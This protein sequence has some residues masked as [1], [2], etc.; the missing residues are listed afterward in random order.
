MKT[1]YTI[2]SFITAASGWL[3][4]KKTLLKSTLNRL[5]CHVS[6]VPAATHRQDFSPL[7]QPIFS[8]ILADLKQRVSQK[9]KH[10]KIYSSYKGLMEFFRY[11]PR[12]TTTAV[13]LIFL[14]SCFSF[15]S[16]GLLMTLYP[17]FFAIH[18]IFCEMGFNQF[19]ICLFGFEVFGNTESS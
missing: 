19:L 10:K 5:T 12:F 4:S 15:S 8:S 7:F 13:L 16:T 1:T 2:K 18:L 17:F 3:L 14:L 9:K 11:F 6:S